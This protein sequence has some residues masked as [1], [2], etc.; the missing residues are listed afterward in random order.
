VDAE[1]DQHADEDHEGDGNPGFGFSEH[2]VL[3]A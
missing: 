2:L 1:V 3:S